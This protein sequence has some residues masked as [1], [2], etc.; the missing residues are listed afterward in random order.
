M[1]HNYVRMSLFIPQ[2]VQE[3][4][5]QYVISGRVILRVLTKSKITVSEELGVIVC[6]QN[7]AFKLQSETSYNTQL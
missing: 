7:D 2:Y 1:N 3:T 4:S 6:I 5:W